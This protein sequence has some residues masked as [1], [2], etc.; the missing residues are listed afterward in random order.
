MLFAEVVAS[1]GQLCSSEG[2]CPSSC[3]PYVFN[4]LLRPCPSS[5]RPSSAGRSPAWS[6]GAHLL[7]GFQGP[8]LLCLFRTISCL[9]SRL[10]RCRYDRPRGGRRAA[11]RY[12]SGCRRSYSLFHENGTAPFHT[13]RPTM[14]RKKSWAWGLTTPLT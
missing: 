2:K 12:T 7:I 14:T 13:S 10:N 1:L 4:P 6:S 8:V 9:R 3:S 11:E 5:V